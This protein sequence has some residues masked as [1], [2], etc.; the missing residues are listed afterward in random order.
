MP[1]QAT[2][3]SMTQITGALIGIAMVLAAVFIPMASSAVR[4]A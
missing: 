3:K 4:R 1:K 2:R